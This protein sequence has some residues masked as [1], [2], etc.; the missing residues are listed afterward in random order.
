MRYK[1]GSEELYDMVKDP[2][3]FTNLA[4]DQGAVQPL[5]AMRHKLDTKLKAIEN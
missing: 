4:K 2:K 1:D 5:T 3:Q